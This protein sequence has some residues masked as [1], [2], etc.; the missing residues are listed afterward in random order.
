MLMIIDA[1]RS[2]FIY[3]NTSNFKFLRE[4]IRHGAAIPY[5]TKAH[6]PTVTLPRIKS[7][8][9]GAIPSFLDVAANLNSPELSE[10]NVITRASRSGS[11]IL[12]FGDETWLRLF[13]STFLRSDGTTA[14]F[15][16]DTKIVDDNV[17]RHVMPELDNNDW[18]LMILHYLGLDHAG[19]LGGADSETMRSK[20]LEMDELVKDMSEKID[21]SNRNSQPG[22]KPTI[23]VV[24]SDHGMNSGGNHGGASDPETDATAI[25]FTSRHDQ[26]DG[27]QEA[28]GDDAEALQF[29]VVWQV[30][31]AP[32]L[33]SLLNV[34]V[35][36]NNIGKIIPKVLDH[37]NVPD[38]LSSLERNAEQLFRLSGGNGSQ[39]KSLT[40]LYNQ[41]R[42]LKD[43]C[44]NAMKQ[45]GKETMVVSQIRKAFIQDG[46]PA[47][48]EEKGLTEAC[49]IKTE[50]VYFDYLH[51]VCER[52]EQEQGGKY[53]MA[54]ITLALF[55]LLA[56]SINSLNVFIHVHISEDFQSHQS[57][58][59]IHGPQNIIWGTISRHVIIGAISSIAGLLL[60]PSFCSLFYND[61]SKPSGICAATLEK[62]VIVGVSYFM[63]TVCASV[64]YSSFRTFSSQL[65]R[66]VRI[67]WYKSNLTSSK[68]FPNAVGPIYETLGLETVVAVFGSALHLFTLFSS[69]MI[70]E[71]HVTFYFL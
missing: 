3:S 1:M 32:T 27:R 65:L 16:L 47:H 43:D 67:L 10:D 49:L 18:D 13:P 57:A 29:P 60:H 35:P 68:N 36:M 24:C 70:E 34:E 37:M 56:A 20:Q 69:S 5:S 53:D 64:F 59:E 9:T 50:K 11:Q 62:K 17:T 26:H 55:V 2:E 66:G 30:D 31:M 4:Q 23:L 40:D 8:I 33:A 61:R 14:F 52:L 44:L 7:I 41:A 12:M 28:S 19:H 54:G 48:V 51:K 22:S 58:K 39:T 6:P 42:S 38:Y 15:V 71:E 45:A 63:M 46:E 25:F 21:L